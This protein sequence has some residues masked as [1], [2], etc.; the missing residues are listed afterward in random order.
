MCLCRSIWK[1]ATTLKGWSSDQKR[2]RKIAFFKPTIAIADTSSLGD[3]ILRVVLLTPTRR[4]QVGRRLDMTVGGLAANAILSLCLV[5]GGD[6]QHPAE[7]APAQGGWPDLVATR[8]MMF[9]IPFGIAED[10]DSQKGN[11]AATVQLWVSE[12]R[13]RTW[14]LA[15][16]VSSK[17]HGFLFR[18]EHDGELYFIARMLNTRVNGQTQQPP[19]HRTVPELR[20][21]V[22]TQPPKLH[23]QAWRGDAGQICSRWV[24]GEPFVKPGSF[25]IFYR[26][27]RQTSRQ[28]SKWREIAIDRR[29]IDGQRRPGRGPDTV[30]WCAD[31]G[32][33]FV[34]IR[35]KVVDLAGNTSISH[36][37]VDMSRYPNDKPGSLGDSGVQFMATKPRL[38][39]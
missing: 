37:Y 27:G 25:H 33:D 22:D 32:A 24:V 20:V 26:S 4:R 14:R 2:D 8:Q 7:A 3:L 12:D 36:A 29:V 6:V 39:R 35:A 34:E 30:N 13:G 18:A 1:N 15:D 10:D 21:L 28:R 5:C 17:R 11:V 19:D 38:V 23:L 9:F 31:A 16:N